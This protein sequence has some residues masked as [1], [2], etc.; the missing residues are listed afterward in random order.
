MAGNGTGNGRRKKTWGHLREA[1]DT[2]RPLLEDKPA[3]P[4]KPPSEVQKLKPQQNRQK[5][6]LAQRQEIEKVSAQVQ[7]VQNKGRQ[8]L[9]KMQ[10]AQQAKRLG[11]S[12][13]PPEKKV[14]K[15]Q[16]LRESAPDQLILART[17]FAAVHGVQDP[18]DVSWEQTSGDP[19]ALINQSVELWIQMNHTFGAWRKFGALLNQASAKGIAWNRQRIN[20]PT[21]SAMG[22]TEALLREDV[23]ISVN[24][25][26]VRAKQNRNQIRWDS[27]GPWPNGPFIGPKAIRRGEADAV[28]VHISP[29]DEAP[30]IGEIYVDLTG[31]GMLEYVGSI[32]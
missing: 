26:L 2:G 19:A 9:Q 27:T 10:A 31:N 29:K 3:D 22:L 8:D 20:Q 16:H 11:L 30:E 1:I 24:G 32:D 5:A 14:A 12:K 4:G 17:I 18:T 15:E 28:M 25:L 13:L 6:Q 21:A 7:D 23:D